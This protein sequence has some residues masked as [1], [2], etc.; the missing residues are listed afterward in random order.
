MGLME[1]V[2]GWLGGGGTRASVLVLGL[3]NSGKSSLLRAL[4]TPDSHADNFSSTRA[5][6]T[7]HSSAAAAAA[8]LLC[9]RILQH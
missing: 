7:A 4:R 2:S 6:R 5:L 3:D 1:R 9:R 8:A